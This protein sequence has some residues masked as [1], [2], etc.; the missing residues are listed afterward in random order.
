MAVI[1]IK[2]YFG[3]MFF[4][5]VFSQR[6]EALMDWRKNGCHFLLPENISANG[7]EAL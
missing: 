7:M 6:R 3:R 5:V 4:G 2:I 1:N